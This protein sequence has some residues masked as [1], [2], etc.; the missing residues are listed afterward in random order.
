MNDNGRAPDPT[1]EELDLF[2]ENRS[3]LPLSDLLPYAGKHV[4][5]SI[6]R[7]CIV[8]SADD[9]ADLEDMVVAAGFAPNRVVFGYVEDP[10]VS[11]LG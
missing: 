4:A 8:A 11:Y 10:N 7:A 9:G 2:R 5:W 3:K 6:D 1:M